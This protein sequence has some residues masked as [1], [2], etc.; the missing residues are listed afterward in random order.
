MTILV[1]EA[2]RYQPRS[3]VVFNINNVGNNEWLSQYLIENGLVDG[4]SYE[5]LDIHYEQGRPELGPI[6]SLEDIITKGK[7]EPNV[8]F[9]IEVNGQPKLF[10]CYLF[11]GIRFYSFSYYVFLILFSFYGVVKG[12]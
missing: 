6:H 9:K 8:V 5:I 1:Q 7:H 4:K 3:E 11:H 12:C 2:R 10:G